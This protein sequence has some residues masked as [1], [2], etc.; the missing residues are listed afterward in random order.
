MSLEGVR[1][2]GSWRASWTRRCRPKA[3]AN[4][5][6]E[7]GVGTRHWGVEKWYPNENITPFHNKLVYCY[8]ICRRR[9][10]MKTVGPAPQSVKEWK[11]YGL[12]I[13]HRSASAVGPINKVQ[14]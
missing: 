1:L 5:H 6:E 3:R 10:R 7:Q 14:E 4:S 11:M 9:K 12:V 2:A 13:S 8:I